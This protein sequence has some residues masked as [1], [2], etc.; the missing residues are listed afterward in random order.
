[1][2]KNLIEYLTTEGQQEDRD[3]T[4]VWQKADVINS[5]GRLYPRN[6]LEKEIKRI[7]QKISEGETVYGQPFHPEDGFG[8]TTD[9]S[10]V[11]KKIWIEP[12]GICKGVISLL[13]TDKGKDIKAILRNGRKLGISSRGLG[14][15][16]E[17]EINGQKIKEIQDDFVLVSPG[18]WVVAPSVSEAGGVRESLVL[19][20][21]KMDKE[22]EDRKSEKEKEPED[23]SLF[24]EEE[25]IEILKSQFE[26]EIRKNEFF[27]SWPEW[28]L[29]NENYIREK[30][31]FP[32][33]K[34]LAEKEKNY[35]LYQEAKLAGWSGTLEEFKQKFSQKYGEKAV[36]NLEE[37]VKKNEKKQRP[38]KP[39]DLY[40]E[41]MLA[42]MD[43]AE[44][45]DRLNKIEGLVVEEKKEQKPIREKI[46]NLRKKYVPSK[47][48][49]IMD[50]NEPKGKGYS[51]TAEQRIAGKAYKK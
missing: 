5:N 12:D 41:A 4:V 38:Y 40:L 45:A 24:T 39:K 50:D 49:P 26:K 35:R 3:V 8:K 7:N 43:P 32:L 44:M 19:M 2:K 33:N 30:L 31:G 14:S 29:R 13:D 42:G 18:D 22:D 46:A 37:K 34:E 25:L 11:W 6:I 47:L 51:W 16:V 17:K 27:G 9:I 48:D 20:E 28:R 15:T 36:R 1:M 10:H 23:V 21:E